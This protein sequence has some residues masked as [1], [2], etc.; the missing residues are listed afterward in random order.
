MRQSAGFILT[1]STE[2]K[3][4]G[5]LGEE[6][7]VAPVR[8]SF[9]RGAGRML[10][11]VP[12]EFGKA[13]VW[14]FGV[15]QN[16]NAL[17]SLKTFAAAVAALYV[18]FRLDFSQPGW[19]AITVYIVSQPLSGMVISKAFARVGG[20]LIGALAAVVMVALFYGV[21]PL[22][23]GVMALWV[24][25]C[26][27]CSICMRETPAAYAA[28]LAGYTAGIVGFSAIAMPEMIFEVATTRCEEIIVG[29]TM[30]TLASRVVLPRSSGRVFRY[31]VA[32]V[33]ADMKR[34][35]VGTLK[36]HYE[37]TQGLA[38]LRKLVADSLALET[39][40]IHASRDTPDVRKAEVLVRALQGRVLSLFSLLVSV[41]DRLAVLRRE[42]PEE[43]A[44]FEPIFERVIERV[45]L[46]ALTGKP[47]LE[48]LAGVGTRGKVELPVA[49]RGPSL[50]SELL[51]K[52][53]DFEAVKRDPE[54]VLEYNIVQRL[55]DILAQWQE[56]NRLSGL[57]FSGVDLEKANVPVPPPEDAV[58]GRYRDHSLALVAAIGTMAAVAVTCAFWIS[59]GW[60]KGDIAATFAGLVSCLVA[61]QDNPVRGALRTLKVCFF[62][63][64]FAAIYLFA[65]LPR[66]QGFEEMAVAFGLVLVPLGMLMPS[67]R[68][69]PFV[70]PFII[71]G[72]AFVEFHNR[73]APDFA[74]FINMSSAL[75]AGILAAVFGFRLLRPMG[76]DWAVRRHLSGVM[77]DLSQ[78]AFGSGQEDRTR[79]ETRMLDRI[80][81]ITLRLRL[82]DA[83]ECERLRGVLTA[84]RVGLNS[85][86]LSVDLVEMPAPLA[87]AVRRALDAMGEHFRQLARMAERRAEESPLRELDAAVA[88]A[89]E[90][91]ENAHGNAAGSV[92]SLRAIRATLAEHADFYGVRSGKKGS[93]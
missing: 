80:N 79:F 56:V 10:V 44:G 15:L 17:Y 27:Y 21:Q 91:G 75:M 76:T 7:I 54:L 29:I 62:S 1:M 86:R 28:M 53:P 39:L 82:D 85:Y 8:G 37:D 64:A 43:A 41:H 6:G 13:W 36:G 38:D 60:T 50:T 19:A 73:M 32:G 88:A 74:D 18:S 92:V 31:R 70:V 81:A 55:I 35:I 68:F 77:R 72:C 12:V 40:R 49:A 51:A 30:A 66:L 26:L 63:A 24:G 42:R 33:L 46:L 84:L 71:H 14:L 20:T 87:R 3:A 57:L 93:L 4:N 45:E 69:G 78:I 16:S 47:S 59:T 58:I 23:V 11:E 9:W 89:I 61:M 5:G 34:C 52:L 90:A 48:E 2:A 67:P 65:I 83:R 25:A 22:F